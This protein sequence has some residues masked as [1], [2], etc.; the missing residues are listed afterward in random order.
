MS[1]VDLVAAL[2]FVGVIAYGI[3]GGADY[4]SG[5]WDLVAGR[6]TH[7]PALRTQIDHSIGP[8]WEANHVWL[9]YILV[10]MW[11]AFPT[12]FAA[13]VTT[14]WVPWMF[15]GL[16]IV[17]RGSG[18]AFRKFSETLSMA[19][20]FGAIFALSSLITPFFLGMIAGGVVNGRVALDAP[21]SVSAW[22][23]PSSWVGGI[24]STSTAAFLA[25]SFLADDARRSKNIDLARYCGHRAVVSGIFT[26]VMA[27]AAV[28]LLRNDAEV[29]TNRLQGR[30]LPLAIMSAIAGGSAIVLNLLG[31]YGVARIGSTMA[32]G[33]VLLGWGIAQ[34][35]DFL[36]GTATLEDVAGARST[37]IG[38]VIVFCIAAVTAVPALIWLFYLVN[39]RNES[40]QH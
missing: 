11:T 20:I 40:L 3:F 12:G 27:L 32:V 34:W 38:L 23:G 8:V 30:G 33:T 6:S 16:G 25:A 31:R 17:L 35:P 39:R 29:L 18:F 10:F 9:I 28:P 19:R 13:L 22:T 24:L 1:L 5:I 15:V 26:G 21:S 2:M 14:M 37:L 4:G 7:A 36:I